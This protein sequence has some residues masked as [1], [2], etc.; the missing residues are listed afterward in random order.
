MAHQAR[1]PRQAGAAGDFTVTCH[2]A[3]RYRSDRLPDAFELLAVDG[4]HGRF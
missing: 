4:S 1:A 2:L 3:A